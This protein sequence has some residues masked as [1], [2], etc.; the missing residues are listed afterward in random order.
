MAFGSNNQVVALGDQEMALAGVLVPGLAATTTARP[1]KRKHSAGEPTANENAM[2]VDGNEMNYFLGRHA[3]YPDE[4]NVLIKPMRCELCKATMTSC[5]SAEDHYYSRGHDRQVAAWITK[6]YPER[7]LQMTPG[8]IGTTAYHCKVCDLSLSSASHARQH[9][10]GRKHKLVES[11]FSR[12]SDTSG[13]DWVRTDTKLKDLSFLND[14][15]RSELPAEE[16]LALTLNQA[17]R[18]AVVEENAEASRRV[19]CSLC[20]IKVTSSGQMEMHVKGAKHQ[21]NLRKMSM[22]PDIEMDAAPDVSEGSIAASL[23]EELSAADQSM[24]RTP[25]GGYYCEPC[26]KLMNHATTLQQHLCG[27]KHLRTVRLHA[28]QSSQ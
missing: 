13:G 14:I 24:Y 16:P 21:K 18:P 19:E 1:R 7:G 10:G 6:T 17:N 3:G 27:K 23:G 15:A 9:Y 22:E 12:T 2:D 20:Q 11:K 8:R 26:K 5:K 28:E 25:T 4:L